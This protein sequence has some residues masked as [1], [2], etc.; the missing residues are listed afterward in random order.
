M[1]Q[2]CSINEASTLSG[3]QHESCDLH[4]QRASQTDRS[5]VASLDTMSDTQSLEMTPNT[6][7]ADQPRMIDQKATFFSMPREI[8]DLIY[9]YVFPDIH[10]NRAVL[11]AQLSKEM[12]KWSA[13]ELPTTKIFGRLV[14][15]DKSNIARFAQSFTISRQFRDEILPVFYKKHVFNMLWDDYDLPD[16]IA[17]LQY[18]LLEQL[19]LVQIIRVS[20]RLNGHQ[21][22]L[23][24]MQAEEELSQRRGSPMTLIFNFPNRHDRHFWIL[25]YSKC[26]ARRL[27]G[28]SWN[29]IREQADAIHAEIDDQ[30]L[31]LTNDDALNSSD[32]ADS[33][34]DEDD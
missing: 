28:W 24:W 11:P 1:E 6:E 30:R 12:T 19:K 3:L 22:P 29:E 16:T 13:A 14:T 8:R 26:L 18:L 4:D 9:H 17:W 10:I 31:A 5:G 15:K 23:R 32:D 34:S 33:D 20:V 25:A 2:A 21:L 27:A 7:A